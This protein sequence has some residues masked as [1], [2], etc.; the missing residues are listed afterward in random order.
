MLPLHTVLFEATQEGW[1]EVKPGPHAEIQISTNQIAQVFGWDITAVVELN[2]VV[3][4]Q[5]SAEENG[6]CLY[7][8]GGGTVNDGATMLGNL[9]DQGGCVCELSRAF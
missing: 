1:R 6:G 4:S 2:D 9:A 3:C 5:N 8:A 7:A